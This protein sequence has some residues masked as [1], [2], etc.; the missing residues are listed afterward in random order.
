MAYIRRWLEDRLR[1]AL[2]ASPAVL[3]QGS[4]FIGKTTLARRL[5][6]SALD[7]S[8]EQHVARLEL[9]PLGMLRRTPKPV[10]VDEWQL[11]PQTLWD[12]KSLVDAEGASGFIIAGSAGYS[13]LE[14]FSQFP[15][16]GRCDML[17]LR[18]M[19]QAERRELAVMPLADLLFGGSDQ[20]GSPERLEHSDY[21]SI[22]VQSGYPGHAR[23]AAD[24][25][26]DAL[27][28]IAAN[29]IEADIVRHQTRRDSTATRSGLS[30]FIA[31]Y[32][33]A[34]GRIVDLLSI[35]KAAGLNDKTAA[36]YRD[37]YDNSYL[38]D[39]LPIWR[40]TADSQ[41][42]RHPK[43]VLSDPAMM[44]PL[45]GTS[46]SELT[47]APQLLGG[48][49]ETFVHAQLSAQQAVTA[50]PYAIEC[51]DLRRSGKARS[52]AAAYPL[53]EIDF[54]LRSTR[55]PAVAVVEVKARNRVK[56]HDADRI[57]ALRDAIDSDPRASHEFTAGAVLCCGDIDPTPI[58]DRVW[59]APLS[60]LWTTPPSPTP[61]TRPSGSEPRVP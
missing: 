35:A 17:R 49:I 34:S 13:H 38:L 43:R 39:E 19:A 29:I 52:A 24:E 25:A 46:P 40:P 57:I 26:H 15:L 7:M 6:A 14:G 11:R 21:V 56:R 42:F 36:K 53:G 18:P 32:A 61:P 22:A 30:R 20:W 5:S 50:E 33:S 51:Y 44:A 55:R 37:M 60:A 23:L 12:I 9:D 58:S 31:A 54:V 45:I 48:L 59:A 8:N 3:L 41:G 4:R 1:D 47:A 2:A 10:L 16:T 27:R 28:R